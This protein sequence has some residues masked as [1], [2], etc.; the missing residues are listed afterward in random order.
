[1]RFEDAAADDTVTFWPG[2]AARWSQPQSMRKSSPLPSKMP[3]SAVPMR[4]ACAQ[5]VVK[6]FTRAQV[7]FCT[8]VGRLRFLQSGTAGTAATSEMPL[9]RVDIDRELRSGVEIRLHGRVGGGVSSSRCSTTERG[10]P[11]VRRDSAHQ[12]GTRQNVT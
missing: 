3:C 12:L 10:R 2:E 8:L 6:F 1:M 11:A 7:T 9:L 5:G 4:N